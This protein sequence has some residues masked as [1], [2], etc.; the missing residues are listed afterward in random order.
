MLKSAHYLAALVGIAALGACNN[1]QISDPNNPGLDQ[2]QSNPTPTG[3]NTAAT[4]LL[5]GSRAGFA[6]QNGYIA[7]L[8]IL[9]R[10][11]YNLD[12]ADPRFIT[13]MLIGPLDGGSPAFGGNI[14]ANPYANI[15]NA[16]TLLAATD[17][18]V[19]LTDQQK[20]GIR[21]FAK[22]IKAHDLLLV[23]NTR[24]VNG[25]P[26]DVD[27]PPTDPPAPIATKAEV[28]TEIISL[29]NQAQGHLQAAGS[30]FSFA[31]SPGFTG[32]DTPAN[33]LKF[34][35]A[36][37]ARVAVYQSDWNTALTALGASFL[38]T[39]APL[40]LGVYHVFGSGSGDQLNP[41]FDPTGRALHG[42]PSI[43]TDA[44]R[45]ADNTL[46][47]R[48]Q[49]KVFVGSP[50]SNQGIV[51]TLRWN[52]YPTNTSPVPI[53]R[54][55]ELILLRAE[56][57]LGLGNLGAAL[58]DINLIRTTSGGLP[59][60]AGPVTAPALLD[61]LL[62]NR[63][64]SLLWE[65]GHRWIDARRYNRLGTLPRDFPTHRVFAKFPFPF[66]ECIARDPQPQGCGTEAGTP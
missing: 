21:G 1:L 36:L 32:F 62:Y 13:E 50:V 31:L 60:F 34:N 38:D 7:L 57:Q 41:L 27:R 64:Y 25:A 28:F 16:N 11:G 53:I 5:I 55:E 22:T 3:V 59:P 58:A 40:T 6:T 46:D 18:V 54:N 45:R 19:G 4:G 37:R 47:L 29:L 66:N 63:R 61:E 35:R 65:G 10:E 48:A 15:R 9:G 56:A 33:F 14:W 49:N 43:L 24:D 44:Q 17:K 2:L 39:N 23:I 20:E 42:H 52:V 30:S 8:G 12:P 51:A 26:I